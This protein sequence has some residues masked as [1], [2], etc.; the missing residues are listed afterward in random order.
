MD[1]EDLQIQ[2]FRI[3]E[4]EFNVMIYDPMPG[5]SGLLDQIIEKWEDII[6][7]G[8]D[9]L[10]NC[11]G[12]CE[13]SCYDCLRTYRNMFY[14]QNL[15]RHEA[16]NLLEDLNT[17][18]KKVSSLPP[19]IINR[20]GP[21]GGSTNTPEMRLS[22]LLQEHG[23]PPFDKQHV[24]QMEGSI[25]RTKPDFYYEDERKDIRIAIYLDGLS[26]KIHGNAERQRTDHFIRS[27]L[28][29][30]GYNVI[31]IAATDLDDPAVMNM[32]VNSLSRALQRGD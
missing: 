22:R 26:K 15:D 18:P 4:E 8:V 21:K 12:N 27:Y 19:N 28:R 30:K 14:H 25:K 2:V 1:P 16:V 24:I 32:H 23:F 31:E 29:S 6:S 11:K 10:R 3:A 13:T 20:P 7:A 9:A 17:K 5:G